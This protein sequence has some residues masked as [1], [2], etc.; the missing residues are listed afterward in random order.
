MTKPQSECW[1]EVSRGLITADGGRQALDRVLESLSRE[2]DRCILYYLMDHEPADF[3][4][5][6]NEVVV[7][8]T[9]E[10]AA[11]APEEVCQEI[12]MRLYHKRLPKLADLGLI[13]YDERS[14]TV[15]YRN[16]PPNLEEFLH[17][18]RELEGS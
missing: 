15:R 17:L 8:E 10:S 14:G 13:E 11:V 9:D 18:A 5:L 12:R 1:H 6:V 3:E 16:P 7:L 2:Y 4:E